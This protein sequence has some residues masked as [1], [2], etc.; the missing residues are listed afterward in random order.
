M[1]RTKKMLD[2][3]TSRQLITQEQAQKIIEY[4]KAQSRRPWILYGFLTLGVVIIAIG[5]ISLIAAN[6][7]LLSGDFKLF[8]NFLLLISLAIGTYFVWKK[9]KP[10]LFEVCLV[11]FYASVS[12]FHWVD[13]TGLSHRWSIL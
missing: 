7:D 9:N 3:W 12:S 8:V 13:F 10:I 11:F 2:I 4:E 5:V 1:S 6:W